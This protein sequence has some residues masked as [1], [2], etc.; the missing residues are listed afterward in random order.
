MAED[1]AEVFKF[2]IIN[3]KEFKE[4]ISKDEVLSKK[5]QLMISRLKSISKDINK[6]F[7]NKLN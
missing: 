5:T 1:K 6:N 4:T 2:M 3:H 7:W